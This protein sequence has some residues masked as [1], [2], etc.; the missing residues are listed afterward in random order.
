M[1]FATNVNPGFE[2]HVHKFRGPSDFDACGVSEAE[3]LLTVPDLEFLGAPTMRV[4][5]DSRQINL[6]QERIQLT[7]LYLDALPRGRH[8][9]P[10]GELAD[11]STAFGTRG[12]V[13][14]LRA[15]G[16]YVDSCAGSVVRPI[17]SAPCPAVC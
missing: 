13:P 7:P 8:G 10:Q 17:E 9:S 4:V 11:Y 16:P 6:S 1:P 2:K 14:I 15:R 5:K 12:H 3:N